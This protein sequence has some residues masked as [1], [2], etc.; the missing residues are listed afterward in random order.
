MAK[1]VR[2]PGQSISKKPKTGG[3]DIK[4]PGNKDN[5]KSGNS[6]GKLDNIILL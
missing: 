5:N 3:L 4:K 1:K 6:L 2:K